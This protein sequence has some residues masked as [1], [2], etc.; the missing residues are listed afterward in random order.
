VV[1][2]D[3]CNNSKKYS[4]FAR[5]RVSKVRRMFERL[6]RLTLKTILTTISLLDQC[7]CPSRGYEVSNALN[8]KIDLGETKEVE[9]KP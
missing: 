7:R 5:V 8:L 6:R 3:F 2:A 9:S 4:K 1:V